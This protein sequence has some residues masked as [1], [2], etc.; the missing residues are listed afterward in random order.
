MH[1][2]ELSL[3]LLALTVIVVASVS[4]RLGW[5]SP[6]VLT[7]LGLVASFLP[8][9]PDEPLDPEIVL[10]G[11]LPPLLFAAAIQ[12]SL[13]DFKRERRA[14]VALSVGLVVV[15]MLT[16]G[17]TAW[18][19]L[20]VPLAAAFALGAVVGPPD[21]VAATAVGRRIGL[22]RRVV[23]VLEGESLVN[24]ATAI[25][26]LGTTSAAILGAVTPAEVGVDFVLSIVVGAG[27]GVLAAVVLG[28]LHR[29]LGDPRASTALSLV[30]PW[31]VFVPAEEL[32][33]SGVLAVVA[34]GLLLAHRAPV[35]QTALA[36]LSTRINWAT[37]QY[38]AENAVFLLVGLQ[39]APTLIELRRSSLPLGQLVLV[40]VAV[41]VVAVLTRPLWVLL[42]QRFINVPGMR[43]ERMGR[44]ELLVVSWAGMRGVVT[45][46]AALTLPTETPH[47]EVLLFAALVVV[48]GTLIGQ[49]ATLPWFA[50]TMRV[51]GPNAREDSLQAAEVVTRAARAG[52]RAVEELVAERPE[53]ADTFDRLRERSEERANMLWEAI[54]AGVDERGTPGEGWRTLRSH[55]IAAER[56][57]VLRIR[58]SGLVESA[59]L[60]EVLDALDLE[61]ANL[62]VV[63][64]RFERATEA[65]AL[66]ASEGSGVAAPAT[67]GC[68]H[69]ARTGP[70][71]E[72]RTRGCARCEAEG[73]DWV[74]LRL[75]LTCGQVGCC[76]S[77]TGRHATSHFQQTG[78]PVMRSFEPGEQWRWCYLDEQVG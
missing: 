32:H 33:G 68:A 76:D 45:L 39:L 72:P 14:I 6:L 20:P 51:Q 59:V 77:S 47:R 78:H 15:T 56:A 64:T 4:R 54:R 50:R 16:V 12:V 46:A 62:Q 52:V 34:C 25:V 43:G 31:M 10:V 24:D 35:Q 73:L 22:P 67:D 53:L 1:G 3:I 58:D 37:V 18:W 19:L 41:L 70:D 13:I 49:G 57:E 66:G 5:P 63:A 42:V 40:C 17:L 26:L 61:E 75:C 74:H 27:V 65:A 29:R 71:P 60:Q 28:W 38:F 44:G 7:V 23:T 2:T 55:M 30:T 8:F 48:A 36:R 21:A 69:L 9:T 11:L